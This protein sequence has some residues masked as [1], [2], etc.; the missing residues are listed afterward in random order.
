[1]AVQRAFGNARRATA[2]TGLKADGV[3]GRLAVEAGA[4]RDQLSGRAVIYLVSDKAK[5]E[6]A[7][8]TAG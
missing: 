8:A 3:A 4:S 6:E 5:C 2:R 7:L 1:M